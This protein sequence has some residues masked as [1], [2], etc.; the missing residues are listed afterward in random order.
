MFEGVHVLHGA[1]VERSEVGSPLVPCRFLVLNSGDEALWQ[2]PLSLPSAAFTTSDLF[3]DKAGFWTPLLF[4]EAALHVV[5]TCQ[6]ELEG[7]GPGGSCKLSRLAASLLPSIVGFHKVMMALCFP[8]KCTWLLK[9][10]LIT[11]LSK[12]ISHLS[13]WQSEISRR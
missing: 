1:H 10:R 9:L 2:V 12:D 11:N 6:K 5:L 7:S 13:Q 4:Q 8:G 3:Y